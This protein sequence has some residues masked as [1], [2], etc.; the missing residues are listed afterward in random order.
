[1]KMG[2]EPKTPKGAMK[3]EKAEGKAHFAALKKGMMKLK[4]KKK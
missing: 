4:G 3:H 1:M 2:K